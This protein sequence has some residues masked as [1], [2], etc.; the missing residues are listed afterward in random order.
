MMSVSFGSDSAPKRRAIPVDR[1]HSG[2]AARSDPLHAVSEFDPKYRDEHPARTF[3]R[4][5]SASPSQWK[6]GAVLDGNAAT[7]PTE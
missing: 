1:R 2:R 5:G 7:K 3:R 6:A 4:G